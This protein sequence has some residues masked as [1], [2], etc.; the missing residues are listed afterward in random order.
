M[1][2]LLIIPIRPRDRDYTWNLGVCFFPKDMFGWLPL[3]TNRSRKRWRWRLSMRLRYSLIFRPHFR[4]HVNL[5]AF[6][7]QQQRL[8][9][10][11]TRQAKAYKMQNELSLKLSTINS[12]TL[13][14]ISK[15]WFWLHH[16]N[17]NIKPNKTKMALPSEHI[18]ISWEQNHQ[19]SHCFLELFSNK[20]A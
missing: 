15:M 16:C 1:Q 17:N 19:K 6:L 4:Q 10:F 7:Q 9:R 14:H 11:L 20:N 8:Q 12:F 13:L 2:K 18:F 3:S 5:Y